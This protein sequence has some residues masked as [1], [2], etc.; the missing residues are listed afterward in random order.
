MADIAAAYLAELRAARPHGPYHL[1]GWCGSSGIAWEMAR[2]L[3]AA[4]ERP[5]LILLDPVVDSAVRDDAALRSNL[6]VFRRAER[7][8]GTAGPADRDVRADLRTVL[9]ELVDDGDALIASIDDEDLDDTWAHRLRAWRELLRAR[10]G[11]RFPRYEGSVDLVLC[12]EL[13]TGRYESIT[14]PSLDDYRGQWRRLAA[15]GVRIHRVPGDHWG[16]V[17]PPHVS[18]LAATLARIIDSTEE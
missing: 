1:L 5:R 7:L 4:G 14:G 12:A 17:R 13:G 2:Q 3:R 16:A 10:L 6:D 9:R 18:I 15:G 11:Y 8:F